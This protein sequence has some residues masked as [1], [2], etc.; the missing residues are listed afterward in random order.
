MELSPIRGKAMSPTNHLVQFMRQHPLL[1]Y[2]LIAY[3]FSWAYEG[4]VIRVL[5]ASPVGSSLSNMLVSGLVNFPLSLGPTLGAFV[6]T[7]VIQGRA[8]IRQLLRRFVLW[9]RS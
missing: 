9:C 8:G 5:H 4:L 1:C 2:F 6:M 3:A 7:A